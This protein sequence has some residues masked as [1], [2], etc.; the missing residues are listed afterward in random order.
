MSQPHL[1]QINLEQY[2]ALD[3]SKIHNPLASSQLDPQIFFTA[4]H[5]DWESFISQARAAGFNS[6]KITVCSDPTPDYFHVILPVFNNERWISALV[7]S[8]C[9]QTY[10][11][12]MHYVFVDDGSTDK[13]LEVVE[14]QAQRL[15][16]FADVTILSHENMGVSGTRNHG[17]HGVM[18]FI[19]QKLGFANVDLRRHWLFFIDTDDWV[20]DNYF[21][22]HAEL[23][24]AD[25]NLFMSMVRIMHYFQNSD[26]YKDLNIDIPD[27]NFITGKEFPLFNNF[28]Y[29]RVA[30]RSGYRL[31]VVFGQQL[32]FP[33]GIHYGEDLV[34]NWLY[35]VKIHQQLPESRA[36][37]DYDTFYYYRREH[38]PSLSSQYES[39]LTGKINLERDIYYLH[40]F[41]NFLEHIRSYNPN[42]ILPSYLLGQYIYL[43]GK[44]FNDA[45]RLYP[46]ESLYFNVT[47]EAKILYV[48][49]HRPEFKRCLPY[50][51]GLITFMSRSDA[52]LRYYQNSPLELPVTS[53]I[54]GMM[55]ALF[56]Q[57]INDLGF[58]SEAVTDNSRFVASKYETHPEI[59]QAARNQL[60]KF[61]LYPSKENLDPS[62]RMLI[63]CNSEVR[64]NSTLRIALAT[65]NQNFVRYLRWC[66]RF[67]SLGNNLVQ[68]FKGTTYNRVMTFNRELQSYV[69]MY[70][71]D[72]TCNDSFRNIQTAALVEL[73][74]D[75]DVGKVSLP[76]IPESFPAV[77][78]INY[79][80]YSD[81]RLVEQAQELCKQHQHLALIHL[82]VE[83]LEQTS[84]AQLF[85]QSL[86][87]ADLT[88]QSMTWRTKGLNLALNYLLSQEGIDFNWI[89]RLNSNC[90]FYPEMFHRSLRM[91]STVQHNMRLLSLSNFTYFYDRQ[92]GKIYINDYSEHGDINVFQRECG[93]FRDAQRTINGKCPAGFLNYWPFKYFSEVA[94]NANYLQTSPRRH[95]L[96][97]LVSF[98]AQLPHYRQ[99]MPDADLYELELMHEHFIS[100]DIMQDFLDFKPEIYFNS[101]HDSWLRSLTDQ[102]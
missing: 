75:Y 4:R 50:I 5:Y 73:L 25:P 33:E 6:E 42:F 45:L 99:Y 40:C 95:N 23:I 35:T 27:A 37:I 60:L 17:L 22:S 74:D 68:R 34:F 16:E 21:T 101:A 69:P 97:G 100:N 54:Y 83:Q 47:R 63:H 58:H 81:T 10:K 12:K 96:C 56:P 79:Q 3:I 51:A 2:H 66:L 84:P 1:D 9:T 46:G 49:K 31:D 19:A 55:Y 30:A 87:P 80:G 70:H 64:G 57:R 94:F 38:Q 52:M 29:T 77:V 11:G 59:I 13:S 48:P 39:N 89:T 62:F 41:N 102:F 61:S 78:F 65:P 71:L 72:V 20:S 18:Q 28:N 15:R 24:K 98:N 76:T 86:I 92:N 26:S 88:Q 44:L 93:Y 14:Q 32:M 90:I 8:L 36:K 53:L 67:V 43:S 82:D 85:A 91:A 7:D